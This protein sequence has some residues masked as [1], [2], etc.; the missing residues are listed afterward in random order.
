MS[1]YFSTIKHFVSWNSGVPAISRHSNILL[2]RSFCVTV[3][4]KIWRLQRN[5]PNLILYILQTST[6]Y[7][8][9]IF[10]ISAAPQWILISYAIYLIRRI[11]IAALDSVVQCWVWRCPGL[12]WQT[13]L[14]ESPNGIWRYEVWSIKPGQWKNMSENLLLRVGLIRWSWGEIYSAHLRH[15]NRSF[16]E[17]NEN[18]ETLK[19]VDWTELPLRTLVSLLWGLNK[20]KLYWWLPWFVLL[21]LWHVCCVVLLLTSVSPSIFTSFA[22]RQIMIFCPVP[23]TQ[24]CQDK[25]R[26]AG[27]MWRHMASQARVQSKKHLWFIYLDLCNKFLLLQNISNAVNWVK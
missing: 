17:G 5:S 18:L 13:S 11:S 6:V 16:R 19:N 21:S 9:Y 27:H 4:Q 23:L 3:R 12:P 26:P 10:Y 20:R 24:E 7:D 14:P 22:S 1:S 8:L 2:R 25:T 15:L